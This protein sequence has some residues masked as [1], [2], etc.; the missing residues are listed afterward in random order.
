M[1]SSSAKVD[2]I[3][4]EAGTAF[5][6]LS[7]MTMSLQSAEDSVSAEVWNPEDLETL[8][9]SVHRFAVELNKI[10]QHIK[11]RTMYNLRRLLELDSGLILS[12]QGSLPDVNQQP[13]MY[14]I[15]SPSLATSSQSSWVAYA[16][17]VRTYMPNTNPANLELP[18]L[19]PCNEISD[20]SASNDVIIPPGIQIQSDLEPLPVLH[21]SDLE[22]SL[23]QTDSKLYNPESN[24]T[25][26]SELDGFNPEVV[27]PVPPEQLLQSE[28]KKKLKRKTPDQQ[29]GESEVNNNVDGDIC[30]TAAQLLR[31][32]DSQEPNL[33]S[34]QVPNVQPSITAPPSVALSGSALTHTETQDAIMP[35]NSLSGLKQQ[36]ILPPPNEDKRKS[37]K[38]IYI[39]NQIHN[40]SNKQ[41]K[42]TIKKKNQ[43]Q[44]AGPAKKGT[45]STKV[46]RLEKKGSKV[47]DVINQ[48]LQCFNDNARHFD[49]KEDSSFGFAEH[50]IDDTSMPILTKQP[51]PV[52]NPIT[53]KEKHDPFVFCDSEPAPDPLS[54]FRARWCSKRVSLT[55][56]NQSTS[57]QPPATSEITK[58][59]SLPITPKNSPKKQDP[60]AAKPVIPNMA[61]SVTRVVTRSKSRQGELLQPLLPPKR[62]RRGKKIKSEK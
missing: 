4:R 36:Q 41:I 62:S 29:P 46:T 42:S 48:K 13:S 1:T 60:E 26:E 19:A 51:D 31:Y 57:H 40:R 35:N 5:N 61:T 24:E 27:P 50:I 30:I 33:P 59:K 16:V 44:K 14:V 47:V 17:P 10:S 54:T 34:P 49:V 28:K 37:G 8:R 55:I 58:I 39:N 53:D 32:L 12:V 18:P 21:L 45:N 56:P 9:S 15:Q 11:L 52:V 7:E 2:D 20:L 6:K 22:P 23:S 38:S 3:F 25:S 43:T